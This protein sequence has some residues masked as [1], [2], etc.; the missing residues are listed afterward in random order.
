[1]ARDFIAMPFWHATIAYL[2]DLS[3]SMVRLCRTCST[4]RTVVVNVLEDIPQ[5]KYE[6]FSHT[7]LCFL[8]S[9][10][11]PGILRPLLHAGLPVDA[12]KWHPPMV[13]QNPIS[14]VHDYIVAGGGTP[15]MVAVQSG[16]LVSAKLLVEFRAD[17]NAKMENGFAVIMQPTVAINAADAR[18]CLSSVQ[19]L[20]SL[21]ARLDVCMDDGRTPLM[22]ACDLGHV[23][24][25]RVLFKHGAHATLNA[26]DDIGVNALLTA[27]SAGHGNVVRLLVRSTADMNASDH[28]GMTAIEYGR[29]LGDDHDVVESLLCYGSDVLSHSYSTQCVIAVL[30]H[31]YSTRRALHRVRYFIGDTAMEIADGQRYAKLFQLLQDPFLAGSILV[32]V[33]ALLNGYL[34][35]FDFV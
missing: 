27:A 9:R 1:M 19:M 16:N 26:Q 29:Q 25:V 7:I 10:G 30:S 14:F 6:L 33:I 12:G 31:S 34:G 23:S 32:V 18:K 21:Q 15:L 5:A 13:R 11:L 4:L 17:I 8:A 22:L 28:Q 35:G 20:L 2:G 24:L 3:E